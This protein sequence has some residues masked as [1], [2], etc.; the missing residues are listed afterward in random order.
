MQTRKA[1]VASVA[2]CALFMSVRSFPIAAVS[3]P[4]K[5]RIEKSLSSGRVDWQPAGDAGGLVLTVAGPG[6]LFLREE[7]PAGTPPFLDLLKRDG[8][9]LPD[10]SYTYEIRGVRASAKP[11][12]DSGYLVI[13]DGRFVVPS[14]P[15]GS[16]MESRVEKQTI[17]DDLTVTGDLVVQQDACIGA[18]C[19]PGDAI[20]TLK[21]KNTFPQILFDDVADSFSVEHDWALTTNDLV[22]P[23]E[24]FA[25]KDS[26]TGNLALTVEGNAPDNALYV[27]SNGNLGLGTSTPAQ[28][29]H[30]VSSNTPTIRLEQFP[31]LLGNRTWDIGANQSAFFVKDV[32]NGTAT[33]FRI[34]AGALSS[35]LTIDSSGAVGAGT[36]TPASRFHLF[37][38]ADTN[39]ILM[40]ENPH[41]GLNTASVLR[42]KSN[43]AI[44]NF[45]AHG[46]GRTISRFG[47]TLASWAE[48]LQVTG[49]G[50][51]I[52]TLESTPLILGTNSTNR[53]HITGTGSVGIGTTS[54]TS[55]LHVNGGDIRVQG[56][57]FIDDGVA[58]NAPDYVFAPDYRLMPI[59]ELGQFVA[60]ERHLPNVP[61]AAEIKEKGLNL[62]QF[63]MRLLE[64]VEELALYTLSQHEQIK[65]QQARIDELQGVN[66]ELGERLEALEKATGER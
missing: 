53:V 27:R 58:L 29:I 55:L 8:S 15:A 20:A 9:P 36:I 33:P 43:S 37:Q 49:N 65:A 39:T 11:I 51:I 44:V 18:S 14:T 3:E 34:A 21:L 61:S 66:A 48:F 24:Y 62:S 31:S 13:R 38:N 23:G 54:P 25:I 41:A 40:A 42:A 1:V 30:A 50:L 5:P 22:G 47:Q 64:K 19:A 45:Q 2:F 10:G 35:S 4:A 59:E 6:D 32:N 26:V 56:G 60:R 17:N 46:S 63:Q 52:G 16:E 57:S 7:F 28:D 12:L